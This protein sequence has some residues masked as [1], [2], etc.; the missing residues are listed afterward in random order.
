M[1]VNKVILI[2]RITRDI[3]FKELGNNSVANFSLVTNEKY[4]DKEG[5]PQEKATFVEITAWGKLAETVNKYVNKADLL[6]VEGK[7]NL[8]T[9]EDK[10]TGAKRSRLT[11]T[12][13]NI[14]LAPKSFNEKAE[15]GSST[16]P[17]PAQDTA[18]TGAGVEEDDDIPF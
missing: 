15:G 14:S 8:D 9:W 2:G 16:P 7:L 3:E 4:K 11:V 1:N 12:A 17:V 10:D 18:P 13:Q 5:N 6:Y